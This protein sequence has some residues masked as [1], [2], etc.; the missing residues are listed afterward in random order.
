MTGSQEEN[1]PPDRPHLLVLLAP[2]LGFCRGIAQGIWAYAAE[3]PRWWVRIG[4]LPSPAVLARVSQQNLAGVIGFFGTGELERIAMGL[5]DGLVINVSARMTES[6]L[7]R[8][9]TDNV[10][11][12]RIAAEHLL[13]QGFSHFAFVPQTGHLYSIERERGFREAL[14]EA[15][16]ELAHLCAQIRDLPHWLRALP[17]PIGLL[18]STDTRA[19]QIVQICREQGIAVPEEIAV[20]GVDNDEFLCESTQLSLSSVDT[21]GDRVGYRASQLLADVLD[22]ADPAAGP[23]LTPPGGIIV[24]H[25]SDTTA[26]SDPDVAFAM[27]YIRDHACRG[28][29]IEQLVDHL[30]ISRRSLERRF[31]EHL[32]RTLH[33]EMHRV[34]MEH[35]KLLLRETELHVPEIAERCG[36]RNRRRFSKAFGKTTGQNPRDFRMQSR[37]R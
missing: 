15:G 29:T 24:R 32:G 11:V 14:E 26:I 5:C 28:M 10:R 22:G 18:A 36:Y 33:E 4:S 31:R 3:N 21:R 7:S 8:V 30:T 23:I 6:A 13:L 17:K 35:A 25:S 9:L 16:Y 37:R 27:R 2:E 12:G 1:R 20:I 34:Q 19:L